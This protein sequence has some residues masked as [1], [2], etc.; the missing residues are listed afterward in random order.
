MG[1]PRLCLE[2]FQSLFYWKFYFNSFC[3]NCGYS[4]CKVSI[5]IL[6]EVLL[7]L[8]WSKRSIL[9]LLVSILIL[10]EV[11]LQHFGA[12]QLTILSMTSFNPYF[13][14]SSTST[15]VSWTPGSGNRKVSILILL[16]VLLQQRYTTRSHLRQ[17][18]VSILILLEVLLQ[19]VVLF[20]THCNSHSVSILILLEV[21]LQR[22]EDFLEPYLVVGFN[23]YFTGSS[24]STHWV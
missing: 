20:V 24:T 23:P 7:Q 21:L 22:R 10:L 3:P 13:T 19:P 12:L 5:L 14:G 4:P 9:R 11:L 17:G 6:L 16:E 15:K 18:K 2:E 1:Q 8:L